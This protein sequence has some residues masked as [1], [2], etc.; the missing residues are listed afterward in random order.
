MKE[1]NSEFWAFENKVD[2]LKEKL[3]QVRKEIADEAD[4]RRAVEQN[5]EKESDHYLGSVCR[6]EIHR[7]KSLDE[8]MKLVEKAIF[9]LEH[10]KKN[11]NRI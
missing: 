9:E 7:A 10:A 1:R 5:L 4:N 3:Y 11:P 6:L 8:A 2:E